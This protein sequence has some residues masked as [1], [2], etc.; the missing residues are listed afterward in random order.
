MVVDVFGHPADWDAI[1]RV[2][3]RHDLLLIDDSLRG[4]RRD[5]TEAGRVG[6][7]GRAGAF[8]FYPNKQMTTGEGGMIVTDDAELAELCRSLRN[9]GRGAHGHL[10][11]ARAARLQLPP[12]RAVGGARRRRRSRGSTP[13][14]RSASGWPRW[15][16]ERLSRARL[17]AS[18]GRAPRRRDELVR[19]RRH[20][21]RGRRPRRGCSARSPSE[22]SRLAPTS[23][24]CTSSRTSASASER[25]QGR[26]RSPR[27]SPGEPSRCRSTTTSRSRRWMR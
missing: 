20:A 10:A 23:A 21:R 4:D 13:S 15:Y 3:D 7:F 1:E 8:A 16:T 22:A 9:Q 27:T 11:R 12:R 19:L 24:R 25:C 6:S 14:S 26:C 5:A 17:G 18:T 2:A